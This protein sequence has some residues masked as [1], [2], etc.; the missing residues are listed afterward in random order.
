MSDTSPIPNAGSGPN[1]GT[2]RF[3][4]IGCGYVADFYMQTIVN[5]PHVEVVR[6]F[7]IEPAHA[8]RFTAY[9]KVPGVTTAAFSRWPERIYCANAASAP[10]LSTRIL[11]TATRSSRK[12]CG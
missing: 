12:R 10:P 9:W 7:D 5:Y 3:A 1:G 4:I 11:S 2:V 6:A 8:A